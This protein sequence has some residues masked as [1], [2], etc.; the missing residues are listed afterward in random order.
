MASWQTQRKQE[1]RS[2]AEEVRGGNK[3]AGEV[4]KGGG[5]KTVIKREVRK[6]ATDGSRNKEKCSQTLP[7]QIDSDCRPGRL[8]DIW[9][10]IGIYMPDTTPPSPSTPSNPLPSQPALS[11]KRNE[12]V[13]AYLAL[14]MALRL[15]EAWRMMHCLGSFQQLINGKAAIVGCHRAQTACAK[16]KKKKKKKSAR[17][18]DR[19]ELSHQDILLWRSVCFA[20]LHTS[21]K[22]KVSAAAQGIHCRFPTL[23]INKSKQTTLLHNLRLQT[24]RDL[25]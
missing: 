22:R 2:D 15:S 16:R 11:D 17:V 3:Q 23:D 14:T 19:V 20:K 10:L 18:L 24:E 21:R 6:A 7:P 8:M 1:Q 9:A 13:S 25:N 5:I 4:M 12:K